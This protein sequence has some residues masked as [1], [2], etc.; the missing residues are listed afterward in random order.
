VIRRKVNK[1]PIDNSTKEEENLRVIF[2]ECYH[3]VLSQTNDE[4]D[5]T[6]SE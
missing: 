4:S 2:E 1:K 3:D 5:E 6:S